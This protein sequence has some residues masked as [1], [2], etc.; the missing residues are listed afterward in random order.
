MSDASSFVMTG[1][2]GAGPR[3]A[4]WAAGARRVPG[5]VDRSGANRPVVYP[6]SDSASVVPAM[7]RRRRRESPPAT[8]LDG[9]DDEES[10][11][12]ED[13]DP[14]PPYAS[15]PALVPGDSVSLGGNRRRGSAGVTGS[16][17]SLTDSTVDRLAERITSLNV[18]SRDTRRRLVP[19]VDEAVATTARHRRPRLSSINERPAVGVL[20]AL[21]FGSKDVVYDS[22]RHVL[23]ARRRGH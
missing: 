3:V 4:E 9:T 15:R 13:A 21:V 19:T 2:A 22:K 8:V 6:P 23:R 16:T 18:R 5:P 7:T 20:A 1:A 12:P 11:S 14:A 17:V 10:V